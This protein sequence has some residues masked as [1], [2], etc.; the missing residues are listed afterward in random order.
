ME[1]CERSEDLGSEET[2]ATNLTVSNLGA[3]SASWDY[4]DADSLRLAL[5]TEQIRETA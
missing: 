5:L 2:R 4:L 1:W 3:G